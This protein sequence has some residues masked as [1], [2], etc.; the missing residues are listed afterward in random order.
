MSKG[1]IKREITDGMLD[2]AYEVW[3]RDINDECLRIKKTG[4]RY[5]L[6][7]V[8]KTFVEERGV[9]ELRR[10]LKERQ[11]QRRGL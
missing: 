10:A 3:I 8:I 7:R 9:P 4:R 1:P 2:D 6:D 11:R 5:N